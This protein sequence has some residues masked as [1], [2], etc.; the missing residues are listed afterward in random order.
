MKSKKYLSIHFKCVYLKQILVLLGKHVW[1]NEDFVI[2][3]RNLHKLKV[4]LSNIF[5]NLNKNRA[6]KNKYLNFK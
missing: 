4:N 3:F 5:T 2:D 6:N 1:V